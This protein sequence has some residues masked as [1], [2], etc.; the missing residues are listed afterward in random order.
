[1]S[2]VYLTDAELHTRVDV[3]KRLLHPISDSQKPLLCQ[4]NKSTVRYAIGV[5]TGSSNDNLTDLRFDT[6]SDNYVAKYFEV[7]HKLK[8]DR[9]GLFQAYLQIYKADNP[10]FEVLALHCDPLEDDS[11]TH[12]LNKRVPHIHLSWLG[13]P[14]SHS[15]IPLDRSYTKN[16]L[17]NVENLTSSYKNAIDVVWN[18]NIATS[19]KSRK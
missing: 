17:G 16:V 15:H 4:K 11:Q 7:W 14:L 1:M 5:H 18:E 19:F 12:F 13:D 3:I 6:A 2:K 8:Q 9:W 10:E